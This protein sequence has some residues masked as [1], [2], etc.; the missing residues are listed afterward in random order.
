[1]KRSMTE[2]GLAHAALSV[3]KITVLSLIEAAFKTRSSLMS[4]LSYKKTR[5]HIINFS[6]DINV[7][8]P[9]SQHTLVYTEVTATVLVYVSTLY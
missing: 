3:V 8:V 6:M 4:S 5:I 2:P 1:M 9:G 7:I